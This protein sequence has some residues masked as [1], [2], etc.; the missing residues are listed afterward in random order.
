[1]PLEL[2]SR[3]WSHAREAFARLRTSLL[4]LDVLD[5]KERAKLS[6]F[7]GALEA[8]VRRIVLIEALSLDRAA[9]QS[10]RP[11]RA[12]PRPRPRGPHKR[13]PCLR[14]WPRQKRTGPRVRLLGPPTLVSEIWRDQRRHALIARLAAARDRR[15]CP[16][17]ILA[18][19]IDALDSILAAPLRAARRLARKLAQA[20]RLA[21]KLAGAKLRAAP[22]LDDDVLH[23]AGSASWPPSLALNSS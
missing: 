20:P 13:R 22:G 16:A 21:L 2:L 17:I 12:A 23:E 5:K 4:P 1:M 14:L 18:G 8:F 10:R 19:R 15:H 7:L 6:R 11:A 9:L 3:L